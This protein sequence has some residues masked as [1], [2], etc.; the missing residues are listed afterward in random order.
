MNSLGLLSEPVL[1]AVLTP[2]NPAHHRFEVFI[3]WATGVVTVAFTVWTFL[4]DRLRWMRALGVGALC[5]TKARVPGER[6]P[7]AA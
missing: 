7:V 2:H 6:K 4:A 3:V 1:K 5:T